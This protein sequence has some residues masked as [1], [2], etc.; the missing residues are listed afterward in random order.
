MSRQSA[1]SIQRQKPL[2]NQ[3]SGKLIQDLLSSAL[4]HHQAGR[5]ADAEALYRQILSLDPRHAD[6]IHL[7]GMMAFQSGSFET[8]ADLIGKA[9]AID[10][11]NALYHSNLGTVL[12]ASGKVDEA[13]ASYRRAVSLKPDYADAHSNLGNVL[14]GRHEIPEA[15]AHFERVLSLNPNHADA[16]TNLGAALAEQYRFAEAIPHYE[17]AITLKPEGAEA[18]SNLG[19]ALL[20]LD[21]PEDAVLCFVQ[22][23]KLK[24]DYLAAYFNLGNTLQELEK[25]DDAI[26]MYDRALVIKPGYTQ[27]TYGKAMAQLRKGDFPNGWENH[28]Q[29]WNTLGHTP[30]RAY[31]QAMWSGEK[32]TAGKVL[33]WG[34]QGV[35]DEIMFAGLLPEVRRRSNACVLDCDARLKPLFARSFPEI[36]VVSGCGPEQAHKPDIAAHLPA[37]SLPRLFRRS[38]ADFALTKSPYLLADQGKREELRTRYANGKRL[39]GLAWYT[40]N[41]KTGPRR[42]IDLP[43]LAPLFKHDEISW[44]SLQYGLVDELQQQVAAAPAPIHVDPTVDQLNDMDLFAAQIAAM[45]LVIT[46]DN[47]TAHLA[48]A[49]G[50]PVWLMLPFAADWRW[51][52]QREDSPW[53]PSMRLFRQPL[54]GDWRSVVERISRELR[55]IG[56]AT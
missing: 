54:R 11:R 43:L 22:A 14:A 12:H 9:I 42:S 38:A 45:D 39:I 24:P 28:E 1:R 49:L 34:E 48:G 30:M 55:T 5:L 50:V 41:K 20:G 3:R 2:S 37:G 46:I 35:G 33:I 10:K 23:I 13:L 44:I 47:S 4:S 32:L 36:E 40:K 53:Y 18:Y 16:H 25:L 21:K 29:R 31:Q 27:A 8:A 15:M 56:C 7:L 6:S 17:R 26:I 51:M 19:N 52:T